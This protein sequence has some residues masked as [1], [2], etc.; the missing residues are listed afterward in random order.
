MSEPAPTDDAAARLRDA[1]ERLDDAE[2]AVDEHGEATLE[3]L[4]DHHED[5]LA[6]L[7]RYGDSATGSGD[8]QAYVEFEGKVADL[9][10]AVDDDLPG[11]DA[12]D[13][14]DDAL[15]K[16]RVTDADFE[17][18]R[19]ALSPVAD[20]VARLDELA[21]ARDAYRSARH[22]AEDRRDEL[23]DEIDR[24]E[25]VARLAD[26][27]P[28][29]DLS[30]LRDPVTAYDDAAAAAVADALAGRA[31]RD[32]LDWLDSLSA[33]PLVDAPTVP[34]ALLDYARTND[35]GAEPIPDLLD[36]AD[37]SMAKLEHHVT[38][39][40]A[41]KRVVGA[42]RSFLRRLDGDFLALGW[43]PSPAGVLRYRGPE[44]VSALDRID[45]DEA[46]ERL[47]DVQA[48]ARTGR[49]D[50]LREAAVAREE[51]SD[52]ERDAVADGT[53]ADELDAARDARDRLDDALD[54]Y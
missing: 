32:V 26:A 2:A 12:F 20:L 50:A 19:D 6:L 34:P 1:R 30:A 25:R 13:A 52:A 4:R 39:P 7:R 24:L 49:Y 29:R 45:A 42:N 5:A 31:A 37:E 44:F 15:D 51:L 35:A 21:D 41:L 17:R 33:F 10:E 22:A 38:D 27:D 3:R 18:A 53:V 47:R 11:A 23:D 54:A 43:P 16:R 8:F 46:V 9:V 14:Y 48:L 28:D 40:A 36:Y